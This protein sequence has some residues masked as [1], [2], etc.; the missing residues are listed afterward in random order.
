MS[1]AEL[2]IATADPADVDAFAGRVMGDTT[3]WMV[4]TM[5]MFGDRLGLWR[6]LAD[7]GPAT[8]A[9]LAGR[10]GIVERYARE[11][12]ASMAAYGYL[13]Y[14]PGSNQFALPAA[15]APVLA[16]EG[17]L[18]FGGWH[19]LLYGLTGILPKVMD[20]FRHGG[21]VPLS[22]Y[23]T[24]WWQGLERFT[25]GWF[26]Y[27]LLPAWLPA[28]PAVQAVLERGADVADIGCGRGQALIRLAQAYPNG[29]YVGYD[30]HPESIAAARASAN[31]AGVAG[32]VRFEC[33]D[34]S[35]G[36]PDDY[37]LITTFDVIHDAVD[38]PAMLSAIRRALRPGGR[39]VCL[40]INASHRLEDNTG[41]LSAY[42]YGVS[43]L[44]CLTT[45]LAQHGAGLGTCGFNE[46]T[47]RRMCANAGFGT[48]RRV[49]VDNPF[50]ILYEITA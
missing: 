3:A 14:D 33:R 22:S 8:S 50:N 29:R 23:S 44:F 28:M 7:G 16:T 17:P 25:A 30:I 35:A 27:Q 20:A 46:E 38:P 12:L 49:E 19:Q 48:V 43:V 5:S 41:P 26:D 37:D 34:V 15:H 9:E 45:S 47:A 6:A 39:Y 13:T 32:L 10:T 1:T 4:T 2:S 21:G 24:D 31:A 11:W 42:Y 36:I 40:D 18:F